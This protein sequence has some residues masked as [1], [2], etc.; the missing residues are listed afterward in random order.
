MERFTGYDFSNLGNATPIEVFQTAA[1]FD[2]F[3][4]GTEV[5]DY[6]DRTNLGVVGFSFVPN[7]A[8]KINPGTTSYT[9]IVR[10]AAHAYRDGSFGL[11][12]GIGD[13]ARGFAPAAQVPEPAS[14]SLYLLG[15]GL[16]LI[17][18]KRQAGQR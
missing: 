8:S 16:L 1:A 4:A 5:A 11:L 10:T 17:A 7:G 12:D 9:V 18:T 3:Q 6:A 15:L 2:N 14:I 13:N